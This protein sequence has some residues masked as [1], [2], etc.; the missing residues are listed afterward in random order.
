MR[1]FEQPV[2]SV[3]CDRLQSSPPRLRLGHRLAVHPSA[4]AGVQILDAGLA[5]FELGI[6][7]SRA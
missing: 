7:S 6:L 2:I 1:Q 3:H 4:S 5:I